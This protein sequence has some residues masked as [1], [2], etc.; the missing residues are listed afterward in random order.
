MSLK[1]ELDTLKKIVKLTKNFFFAH[2][3]LKCK[4]NHIYNSSFCGSVLWDYTS[5]EVQ[6]FINTWSVSVRHMWNIP[7]Q[8]HKYLIEPLGGTH[9]KTM[10]YSRFLK[11]IHSIETG[12]K[13]AAKLLLEI[14]KNNTETV[15]GR[16]M[17][18]ILIES[19]QKVNFKNIKQLKFCKLSTNDEW[20]IK[21]IN[22]LI[23]IK[24]G[25]MVL[26]FDNDEC[27]KNSEI[28]N[29]LEYVTTS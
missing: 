18:K 6:L 27:M 3:K 24:Q 28:E 8:S 13:M 7:L 19:E 16:N 21:L 25:K 9:L 26:Q 4:L 12:N 15:T 20:R 23:D 22:E 2:P 17:K 1:K 14:I 10:L 5:K 11:F 29:L